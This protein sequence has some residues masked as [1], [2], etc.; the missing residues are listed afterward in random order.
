MHP[1][2]YSFYEGS[3]EESFDTMVFFSV[4]FHSFECG[5]L[6]DSRRVVS[7]LIEAVLRFYLFF[8][9]IAERRRIFLGAYLV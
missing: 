9:D 4:A 8:A 1:Y 2:M 5:D 6:L 3:H 7:A